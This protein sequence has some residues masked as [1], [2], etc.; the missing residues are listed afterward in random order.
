MTSESNLARAQLAAAGRKRD[1]TTSVATGLTVAALIIWVF[2]VVAVVDYWVLLPAAARWLAV[3][4]L[5]SLAVMGG[6]R[7]LQL[8]RRSTTLKQAALDL[9]A[10]QPQLGCEV[11]TAAEYLS[12][13]RKISQAYE[14]DFVAALQ[15]K[16]TATLQQTA[17]PYRQRLWMPAV[18]TGTGLL[19][20][21]IFGA[22]LPSAT[23]ALKRTVAPWS[24]VAFTQVEVN[25]GSVDIPVGHD[26]ELTN[27]F[28]GRI[29]T[30]AELH[31]REEGKATWTVVP[32]T[33]ATRGTFRHT[34]KNIQTSFIY[35][36]TGSDA[37]SADFV[38]MAYIPPEVKTLRINLEHPE[39][40]R[41]KPA[42]Q[43][44]PEVSVIR[45]ST[46]TFHL[47]PTTPLSRARLRFTNNIEL[48]LTLDAQQ[49]WTAQLPILKDAAYQIEL[50]DR[51]GRPN[52]D[53]QV[54]YLTAIPD[55]PPK[56]EMIEPGGDM[57]AGASDKIPLRI[58]ANDDFG[59]AEL[60]VVYHRLGG[61]EREGIIHLSTTTNTEIKA[62]YE[63]NLADLK[64]NE[65]EVV[66]YHALAQ[67]NNNLDGPGIGRSPVYFIEITNLEG[68]PSKKPGKPREKV[69][70]LMVE[71]QIIADTTALAQ[72]AS[73]N[74]FAELAA[75]QMD[76]V[77]F[78]KMYQT[79]LAKSGASLPV[80][81][82]LNVAVN[83]MKEA[84]ATLEKRLRDGALPSEE[85]ALASLYRVM[86]LMPELKE[87]PVVA[88][89]EQKP[90]D[91]KN[92]PTLAVVLE[93]IKK[94]SQEED[95]AKAEFARA[96][97]Q[98][99]Q[100]NRQQSSLSTV[101]QNPGESPA[102]PSP[103]ISRPTPSKEMDPAAA[104]DPSPGEGQSKA[105]GKGEG[106][107]QG[108]ADGQ[109]KGQG[110]GQGSGK[111]AHASGEKT[112][113]KPGEKSGRK[114]G[115]KSGQAKASGSHEPPDE[116]KQAEDSAEKTEAK[117]QELAKLA[118]EQ[119]KLSQQAQELAD[120]LNRLAGKASR[121]GA[122]AGQQ[123]GEAAGKMAVA[124]KAMKGGDRPGA[125]SASNQGSAAMGS[126]IALLE[127]LIQGKPDL[128]DVVSE[129]A[130]AQYESVISDY[131]RR[132]SHA[133]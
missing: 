70:L 43:A 10:T 32:L 33:P 76:A 75:R 68:K 105:E 111:G 6:T 62:D 12:G 24:S 108:Q 55:A 74:K 46:A 42:E 73:S 18:A 88:P 14:G 57:R 107:G 9:E 80:Q 89:K 19:G 117:E 53:K 11:S 96:L 44:S 13:Q 25:P 58:A 125:G 128:G 82:E 83:A 40:T 5:G 90:P 27:L 45:G 84:G 48:E 29:P 97:K 119:E 63:L 22:T 49:Q 106:E 35:R 126:A 72:N 99:Q 122:K 131:F 113:K 20:L 3:S 100:L 79:A 60:K 92:A 52:T 30:H 124:A 28:R 34:L 66:A 132:L 86:Q 69:N 71:K 65:F 114:P 127:S 37:V 95:P 103:L 47:T 104:T 36:V 85:A 123:M 31:F 121:Q 67:D 16:A 15:K 93:A 39:Y 38:A 21:V 54:H 26:L 115:E 112:G 118:P 78:G 133:E 94:R 91:P 17:V 51:K 64:L 56:V 101:T 87:L 110:Q 2:L 41:L 98:I 59:V 61:P 81:G 7:M 1:Q 23:T 8:R 120:R 4:A 109:G 129:E 50:F 116:G 102:R 77:A 130:P